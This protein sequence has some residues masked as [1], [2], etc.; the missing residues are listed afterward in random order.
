MTHSYMR[1][2]YNYGRVGP[3][4]ACNQF[5]EAQKWHCRAFQL[6]LTAEVTE[7]A[8]T[9]SAQDA[10]KRANNGPRRTLYG[11]WSQPQYELSIV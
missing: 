7:G 6:N 2:P 10:A 8:T 5:L 11:P 9:T 4:N 1:Y 3:R